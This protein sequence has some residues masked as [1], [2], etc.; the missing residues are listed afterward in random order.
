MEKVVVYVLEKEGVK[1]I[2]T[3]YGSLKDHLEM[4][5]ADCEI[6]EKYK[7]YTKVMTE[8]EFEELPDDFDGF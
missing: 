7:V 1:A 6:G 5:L 2:Y 4:E 3:D 8:K